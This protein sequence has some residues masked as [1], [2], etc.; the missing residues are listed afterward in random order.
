MQAKRASSAKSPAKKVGNRVLMVGL[1]R[2]LALYR[3]EVLRNHG[4]YV[5]LPRTVEDAMKTIREGDFDAVILSYTL[6]N[7]V[8]QDLAELVRNFGPDRP[9]I[10]ISDTGSA[11]RRIAPDVV[12]IAQDGPRGLIDALRQVLRPMSS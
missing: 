3:A 7:Q 10:V 12:A 2:E 11:D 5:S 4:Y 6:P 1:L 8:V 9:I